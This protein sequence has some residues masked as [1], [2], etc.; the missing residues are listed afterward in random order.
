LIRNQ[1]GEV[2]KSA[3]KDGDLAAAQHSLTAEWAHESLYG[4]PVR[5]FTP[6]SLQATLTA[7]SLAVVAERGIRVISDY[8][9]PKAQDDAEYAQILDLEKELGRRPEFARVARYT[10]C[11]ARTS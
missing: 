8:L 6:E 2:L 7:A 1:A 4:G 3:I 5:L 9:P 10:H 11:V